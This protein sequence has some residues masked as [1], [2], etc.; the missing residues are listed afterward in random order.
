MGEIRGKL[1]TF[2]VIPLVISL[3]LHNFAARKLVSNK[4]NKYGRTIRSEG[5]GSGCGPLL[6]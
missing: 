6:R 4:P 5:A 2:C 3:K 1:F